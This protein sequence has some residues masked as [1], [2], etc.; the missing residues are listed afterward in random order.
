M[1][2]IIIA[3]ALLLL[4]GNEAISWAA[5]CVLACAGTIKLLKVASEGGAFD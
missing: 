5:L 2:K 3:S 1:K 4:L